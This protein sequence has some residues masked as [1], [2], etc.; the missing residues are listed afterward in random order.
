MNWWFNGMM[1]GFTLWLLNIAMEHD[2]LIDDFGIKP[3]CIVDFPMAMLNNQRVCIFPA[4]F[5]ELDSTSIIFV[6]LLRAHHSFL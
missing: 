4:I 3:P 5:A 1:M 2:S 6:T